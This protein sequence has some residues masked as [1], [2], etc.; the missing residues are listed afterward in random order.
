MTPLD[1]L[2]LQV[3]GPDQSLNLLS[4]GGGYYQQPDLVVQSG[5]NYVLEFE[6]NGETISAETYIPERREANI[7][8]DFIEME[9][10]EFTGGFPGGGGGGF[11]QID[12]IEV[13]WNNPEGDYYYVVIDNLEE[14]PEYINSI[15]ENPDLPLRRFN[16]RSE[17]EVSDFYAID[18]RRQ[19]TQFGQYRIVVFRVTPEYAALY[20]TV[21]SSSLSI[22]QPPT[23]VENGLGIFTGVSSDTLYFEVKKI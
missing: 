4:M 2:T 1:D 15:F 11:T 10:I 3:I 19:L 7:S 8:A 21:G 9:K 16:F 13:S 22:T 12:P 20:E 18:P 23:N 14:N 6:F 5:T 17:P